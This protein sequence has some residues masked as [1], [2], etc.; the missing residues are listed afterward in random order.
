[1]LAALPWA[2][3]I[4]TATVV[5]VAGLVRGRFY[6]VFAG[7][8]LTV[9]SLVVCAV[10][11]A[12]GAFGPPLFAIHMLVYVH[13]V[14]LVWPRMRP[15]WYRV[16]VSTP[17]SWFV[18]GTMLAIP[19]AV[20]A[21]AGLPLYG[22]FVP[23]L[24]AALGIAQSFRNGFEQIDLALDGTHVAA[25]ARHRSG[26]GRVERPLRLAQI[27]DPHLGPFM[28]ERRLRSVV[29]RVVAADPDLVLLTGDFLTME[30]H[31]DEGALARALA[32]LRALE[33]RAFACRGNHDL[34]APR[35]V[36]RALASAGVTLLVDD[37]VEVET[38]AGRV[39]VVGLDY[40]FRDRAARVRSVF[41]AH[42]RKPEHFRLVL[43]HDPG[44]FHHLP[45][46]EADLVLSGHTHGGQ[47]GLLSVG[48]PH[49]FLSVFTRIPDHGLWAL[50]RNRLYVHRG[51][52]HYGFPLR[53]GVPGEE[54]L[55]RVHPAAHPG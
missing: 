41:A 29:E 24:L 42:P 1:V 5:L 46:G 26:A 3:A 22:L 27:T 10:A 23:Y 49:T 8:L 16:L 11:P 4:A 13:F 18:A 40:H 55:L 43:L 37:A 39:Q 34:E 48:L 30:S 2:S 38:A 45:D 20:A 7:V 9:H 28:S 19:W 12:F 32:P 51:T 36:A 14:R 21:A 31:H 35:T 6:A 33:G 53:I 47:L 50:G 44:A 25:L 54:S 52:G 15:L 17:A